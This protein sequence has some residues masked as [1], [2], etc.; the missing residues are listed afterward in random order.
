MSKLTLPAATGPTP[1]L[2]TAWFVYLRVHFDA[3]YY[4]FDARTHHIRGGCH[5]CDVA[6][7]LIF[8]GRREGGKGS[9]GFRMQT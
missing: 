5:G 4:F 2:G 3:R 1:D 9:P 8:S 7:L 6:R